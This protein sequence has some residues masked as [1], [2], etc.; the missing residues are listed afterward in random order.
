MQ[1]KLFSM[2]LL[3][4]G[5]IFFFNFKNMP[6][7]PFSIKNEKQK[8]SDHWNIFKIQ[9]SITLQYGRIQG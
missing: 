4:V 3:T 7:I 5:K 9:K 8:I 6:R 1:I 2:Y